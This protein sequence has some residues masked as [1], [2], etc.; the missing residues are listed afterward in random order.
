VLQLTSNAI[1]I[2][3]VETPA[4]YSRRIAAMS[5][6]VSF[7]HPFRTGDVCLGRKVGRRVEATPASLRG[8]LPF[9]RRRL[10]HNSLSF[11]EMRTTTV[12]G[13]A[14]VHFR[15]ASYIASSGTRFLL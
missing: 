1:A 7:L 5:S 15:N 14:L 12:L 4:A 11:Q 8:A 13:H 6:A 3:P 2:W 10:I 9:T